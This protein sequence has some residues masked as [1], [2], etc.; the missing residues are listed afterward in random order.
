MKDVRFVSVLPLSK[1]GMISWK[2]QF[3]REK[4]LYRDNIGEDT[5]I[6]VTNKPL[7]SELIT[8]IENGGVC[9]AENQSDLDEYGITLDEQVL[10]T[11]LFFDEFNLHPVIYPTLMNAYLGVEECE[12][13]GFARIHEKRIVK[14]GMDVGKKPIFIKKKLGLGTLIVSSINFDNFFNING[15]TLRSLNNRVSG[16]AVSERVNQIDK[17]NIS[18]M[19][20][21]LF[22]ELFK[23]L[24]LPIIQVNY[25][26][27][28]AE[29]IFMFRMDLD[30]IDNDH[31]ITD[32]S[33]LCEKY[34]IPGTFYANRNY[35]VASV[36]YENQLKSILNGLNTIGN[37]GIVHNIYDDDLNNDK[38]IRECDEWLNSLGITSNGFVAPR[39]IWNTSL[40]EALVKN[41]YDYTSDFGVDFNDLPIRLFYH[42]QYSKILQIPVNAYSAGRHALFKEEEK[43]EPLTSQDIIDYYNEYIDDCV[44]NGYGYVFVYGHPM[45]LG[46]HLDALEAVFKRAT[47]EGFTIL[48]VKE[49]KDWWLRREQISYTLDEVDKGVYKLNVEKQDE[50]LF[51]VVTGK[52]IK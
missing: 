52:V 1:N 38:N 18:L 15:S 13:L 3:D 35:M 8:F 27:K 9:I 47:S 7:D 19:L 28:N 50:D 42:N 39:G 4:I 41:G 37:H 12:T 49:F 30:G 21:R 20:K 16:P 6:V 51:K 31:T 32:V 33:K 24:D 25:F 2:Q 26:P 46:K 48:S 22:N 40:D 17:G 43:L 14:H 23:S 29:K 36:N 10:V 5:R 44:E 45:G 11:Q 34:Q